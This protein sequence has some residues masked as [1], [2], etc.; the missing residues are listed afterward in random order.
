MVVAVK[1]S[2]EIA[3]PFRVQRGGFTASDSFRETFALRAVISEPRDC[4][5]VLGSWS[6]RGGW[7]NPRPPSAD[8]TGRFDEW[9]KPP[10]AF[11][12]ARAFGSPRAITPGCERE[13]D[14]QP[15]LH[16]PAWDKPRAPTL[17]PPLDAGG[18]LLTSAPGPWVFNPLPATAGTGSCTKCKADPQ[19]PSHLSNGPTMRSRGGVDKRCCR[20]PT[21]GCLGDDPSIC[22]P[23]TSVLA[24][25]TSAPGICKK[26]LTVRCT[27][28]L[29]LT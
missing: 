9:V 23:R 22:Q 12:V 3:A 2:L 26:G 6:R 20:R 18:L 10:S 1:T 24:S 5:F 7:P 8:A 28:C 15:P 27:A 25:G 11:V 19:G 14:C 13:G 16:R 29:G 4:P 17:A 21:P